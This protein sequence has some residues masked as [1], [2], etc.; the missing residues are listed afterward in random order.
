MEYEIAQLR[1]ALTQAAAI[2]EGIASRLRVLESQKH[3]HAISPNV[4]TG[5]DTVL[6][7][8]AKY[9]PEVLDMFD[10]TKPQ[11]TA[12]DG[13]WLKHQCEKRGIVPV[14]V[15][16]PPVLRGCGIDT[17]NAYPLSLLEKR[18]G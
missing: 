8:L 4:P 2:V 12:R 15:I 18:W 6:G 16:A 1:E 10:Y 7:Y 17:V 5:Y 14:I 11:A 13:W 9:H 3:Q